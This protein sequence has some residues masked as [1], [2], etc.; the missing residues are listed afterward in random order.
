MLDT[1]GLE[2]LQVMAKCTVKDVASLEN[3]ASMEFN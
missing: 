3:I 2:L 1:T